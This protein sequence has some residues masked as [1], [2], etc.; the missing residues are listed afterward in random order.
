MRKIVTLVVLIGALALIAG[1]P[2]VA[3]QPSKEDQAAMQAMMEAYAKYGAL[4]APH[5]GL[6]KR[7]GTWKVQ[8]RFWMAPGAPPEVSEG[9][10][11]AT[12]ILGSHYIMEKFEMST[13]DG[14]F[15]GV[16]IIGYDNI[17]QRYQSIWIDS[18]STGV[19]TAEGTGDKDARAIDYTGQE[20]DPASNAY[21]PYRSVEKQL[22]DNTRR[23]ET[24]ENGPDGKEFKVME[25]FYTRE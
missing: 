21:K 22:D 7:V 20:P 5:K 18:M 15:N 14:P 16:S 19:T 13:P 6:A 1:Q 23:L 9:T 3:Q 17:K 10:T 8:A 2:A 11:E 25:L 12:L 24:F 4:G